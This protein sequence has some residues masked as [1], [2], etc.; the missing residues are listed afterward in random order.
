MALLGDDGQ[1]FLHIFPH[2]PFGL[3]YFFF[4]FFMQ[5]IGRVVGGD[6]RDV[7]E[8]EQL[9]MD[10]AHTMAGSQEVVQGDFAQAD[11][12]FGIEQFNLAAQKGQASFDF[13]MQ[14]LT[15]VWWT[16]FY[17]VADEYIFAVIT[18]FLDDFIQQLPGI[19]DKWATE[20]VF[21]L[22]RSF[23]NENDIRVV[24]TFAG[25]IVGL[26]FMKPALPALQNGAV[27]LG[28]VGARIASGQMQEFSAHFSKKFQYFL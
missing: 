6:E 24:G 2:F 23:P 10:T 5:D 15:I 3:R 8:T 20:L 14:R 19:A 21:S 12:N 18:H 16:A 13:I 7:I 17:H 11:Y 25:D 22:T 28:Q 9:A 4:F 26:A 27:Q 1:D